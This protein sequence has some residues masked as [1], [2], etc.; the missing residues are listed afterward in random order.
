M[1]A[2]RRAIALLSTV[3]LALLPGCGGHLAGS[4]RALHVPAE[5]PNGSAQEES[6]AQATL[7]APLIHDLGLPLYPG[8]VPTQGGGFTVKSGHQAITAAYLRSS[9]ALPKVEAF[10]AARLPH[11]SLKQYITQPGDGGVAAFSFS[12]RAAAKSVTLS[13]DQS[14]TII[15]LTTTRRR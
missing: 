12:E 5:R 8:A 4:Q 10:Y 3:G 1:N 6:G 7:S 9:D 13:S 11:G 2:S 14:A 15:S